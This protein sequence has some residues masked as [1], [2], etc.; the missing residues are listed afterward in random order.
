M[1]SFLSMSFSESQI[2]VQDIDHLGILARIIDEISLVE[3]IKQL[4][5]LF[6]KNKLPVKAIES[7]YPIWAT[8]NFAV[9]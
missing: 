7:R 3:Q 4:L 8:V 5:R 6:L 2:K 9:I 1:L